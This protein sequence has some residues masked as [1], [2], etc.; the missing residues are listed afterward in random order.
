[1][2]SIKVILG[3]I[4]LTAICAFGFQYNSESEGNL[5]IHKADL[6]L[7]AEAGI[8]TFNDKPFSGTAITLSADSVLLE[9]ADFYNGKRHG[10][11]TKNFIDGSKSYQANYQNG[12]LH[13]I[14]TT[15]W[16]NGLKHSEATFDNGVLDGPQKK[17]YKSGL[18]FKETNLVAGKESGLQRAWRENGKLYVNYE[19]KSGRIYG[20]KR[21]NL[22]YQLDNESITYED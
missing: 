14:S 10:K 17:W 15:W 21:S 11:L 3:S 4:F 19:A 22:C 20:L 2:R 8:F 5:V 13:G 18:L 9:R 1:M 6:I 16:K 7:K 12:R